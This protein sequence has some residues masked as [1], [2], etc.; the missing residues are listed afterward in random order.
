M[1]G[2]VQ[3]IQL[4]AISGQFTYETNFND[5]LVSSC[6]RWIIQ[7]LFGTPPVL[8]SHPEPIYIMGGTLNLSAGAH[9]KQMVVDPCKE[10]AFSL[11]YAFS[12]HDGKLT[13]SLGDIILGSINGADSQ[14]G[15]FVA[16]TGPKEGF[17]AGP[18]LGATWTPLKF[19]YSGPVGSFVGVDNISYLTAVNEDFRY[20][21]TNW[22]T[23]TPSGVSIVPNTGRDTPQL[24]LFILLGLCAAVAWLARRRCR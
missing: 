8:S 7:K 14:F 4:N 18:E 3:H 11:S 10:E 23:D 16:N 22:T 20:G 5:E 13:V 12:I 9:I 2:I 6:K 15:H 19:E 21:L 17:C 24:A 1:V